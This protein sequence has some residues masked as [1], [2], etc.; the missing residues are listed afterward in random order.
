MVKRRVRRLATPATM[1][2]IRPA[3]SAALAILGS[4]ACL[5]V[6]GLLLALALLARV[7]RAH[8]ES[9]GVRTEDRP[10]L[11]GASGDLHLYLG[12]PDV[13]VL[14]SAALADPAEVAVADAA[15]LFGA[16]AAELPRAT[17]GHADF[18]RF[19]TTPLRETPGAGTVVYLHVRTRSAIPTF[20][21]T[22]RRADY[23][24]TL[25][26]LEGLGTAG[27]VSV[28]FGRVPYSTDPALGRPLPLV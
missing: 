19:Q 20:V 24:R 23:A 6:V 22:T 26:A 25:A 10:V 4:V 21:G 27:L 2:H 13:T 15:A 5:L 3:M 8:E 14:G 16:L 1:P 12:Y 17:H 18:G 7:E 9:V 28:R 11:A